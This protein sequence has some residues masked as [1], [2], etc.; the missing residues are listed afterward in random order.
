MNN[1]KIN[2]ALANGKAGAQ[3]AYAKGNELM[4]KVGFLKKPLHKKIAWGV[5]CLLALLVI[6]RI[7][8]CGGSQS[9]FEVVKESMLAMTEGDL[10][11]LFGHMYIPETERQT[12]AKMSEAELA[13]AEKQIVSGIMK[14]Y[15]AMSEDELA[16]MRAAFASMRHK[17]TKIEGDRAT[18]VCAVTVGGEERENEMTLRKV[19]GEW[20]M[21]FGN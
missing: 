14:E 13:L 20:A 9:P 8:G 6:G 15:E 2:V 5:L 17:S 18:V 12:L 3:A 10:E 1:E 16:V 4:D 11:T 19:D 21:D 7:F